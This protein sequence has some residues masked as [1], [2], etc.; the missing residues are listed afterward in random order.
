MKSICGSVINK[1]EYFKYLG[2]YIRSTK[3]YVNIRIANAWAA[4]NSKKI[5]WKSNLS[6]VLKYIFQ[7]CNRI[8]ACLRFCN[9]DSDNLVRKK[10]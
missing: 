6:I 8:R 5:I 7:S 2:S 4:L 9:L 1:V 10:D 3:R